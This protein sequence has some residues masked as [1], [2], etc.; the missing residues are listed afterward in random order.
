M[1]DFQSLE[2]AI[3]EQGDLGAVDR[4]YRHSA[5]LTTSLEERCGREDIAAAYAAELAQF[6]PQT[7]DE[8]VTVG[9]FFACTLS[10][11]ASSGEP[12]KWRQHRWSRVENN[13]IVDACVIS[14]FAA[15]AA[16]VAGSFDTAAGA[17]AARLAAAE[18]FGEIRAGTG[19]CAPE[20]TATLPNG[21]PADAVPWLDLMHRVWNGRR[22]DLLAKHS[23]AG[24][25]RRSALRCDETL[26]EHRHDLL[27]LFAA[28]PDLTLLFDAVVFD[29]E[30]LAVLFRLHGHHRGAGA[31]T[32]RRVRLL[33]SRLARIREG[34]FVEDEW[35]IDRFAL[36]VQTRP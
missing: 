36:A 6:F 33:G 25:R 19:Q 34:M 30:R 12:V 5:L 29:G 13:R 9:P 16:H 1:I 32:G 27:R 31:A 2:R 10:A 17:A 11:A 7:V 21:V 18:F 24:S 3:R 26:D 15:T 20:E 28:M 22:L 14:D 8:T 4:A 35:L 23:A